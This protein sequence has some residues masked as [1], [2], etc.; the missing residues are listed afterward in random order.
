MLNVEVVKYLCKY[1][2]PKVHRKYCLL[3][4]EW[5]NRLLSNMVP[6]VLV[7]WFGGG[8]REATA[9]GVMLMHLYLDILRHFLCVFYFAVYIMYIMDRSKFCNI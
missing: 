8:G 3:G 9:K 6:S 7:Q 5:L 4:M 2:F 1:L